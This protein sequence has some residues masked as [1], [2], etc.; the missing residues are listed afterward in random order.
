M[1][2]VVPGAKLEPSIVTLTS[3]QAGGSAAK[4]K[5]TV[6]VPTTDGVCTEVAITFID[7]VLPEGVKTPDEEIVPLE[8]VQITALEKLPVP[9]TVAAHWLVCPSPVNEPGEQE[10]LTLV[11][12]GGAE[13]IAV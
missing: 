11:A 6:A 8:V 4:T 7:D 2:T 13:V 3:E 10:T 1:L 12:A 9:R 5:L